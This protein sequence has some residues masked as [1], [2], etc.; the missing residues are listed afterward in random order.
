MVTKKR[1]RTPKYQPGSRFRATI[2]LDIALYDFVK[3]H[4]D[5]TGFPDM[6]SIFHAALE[7]QARKIRLKKG[8]RYGDHQKAE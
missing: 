1:F 6:R 8:H 3:E 2:E 5:A 4:L 7:T